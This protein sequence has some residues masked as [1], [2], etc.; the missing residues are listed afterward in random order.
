MEKIVLQTER[1]TKRY[2][3]KTAVEEVNLCVGRGEIYGFLGPN[4]AGKTTVIH[5]LL[6]LLTPTEG[7][8]TLFGIPFGGSHARI[9]R[10]MGAVSEKPYLYLEMTAVEYLKFIADLYDLDRPMK[11]AQEMLEKLELSDAAGYRLATFSRGMQ[12]KI[13]IA[14]A[15]IHDPELLLFDEPVSGLDPRGIRQVRELMEEARDKGKTVFVSSHLLSEAER[16][17]GRVA[18]INRGRLLIEETMAGIRKR[19]S[20]EATLEIEVKQ[21]KDH[22][23]QAVSRLPLVKYLSK[24]G[25][26]L[27]LKVEPGG[28]VRESVSRTI[29]EAGGTVLSMNMKELSLE[30][31]FLTLT[32]QNIS[33][34]TGSEA[35]E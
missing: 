29:T 21:L 33:L 24:K 9:R 35:H 26:M 17:C 32:N 20:G 11:R 25:D 31:A 12:Q 28:E 2:G 27:S 8:I 5:L 22:I 7:T 34:L 18:I 30:D 10:R 4:G 13:S 3:R 15:L 23:V 19:L 6:G 1:L 14:R 16:V